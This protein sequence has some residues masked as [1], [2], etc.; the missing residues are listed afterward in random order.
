[1]V[2]RA[3]VDEQ[4]SYR[5]RELMQVLDVSRETVL[6]LLGRGTLRGYKVGRDWRVTQEELDR[7]W[8]QQAQVRHPK[9]TGPLADVDEAIA[10]EGAC[11]RDAEKD[12]ARRDNEGRPNIPPHLMDEA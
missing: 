11:T 3:T 1:M 5:V 9:S 12:Q 10:Q 2:G 6:R 7:F 8:N 4:K